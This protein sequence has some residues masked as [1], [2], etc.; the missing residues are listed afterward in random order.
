ML[1]AAGGIVTR[2]LFEPDGGGWLQDAGVLDRLALE[3]LQAAAEAMRGDGWKWIEVALDFPYG[4]TSGLRHIDGEVLELTTEERATYDALQAEYERLE[5][6]HA[7]AEDLP[8]EVDQRLSEIECAIS[9]LENRPVVYDPSAMARAGVFVSIASD[10]E[11][12]IER[13]YVRPEDELR[14]DVVET[15]AEDGSATRSIGTAPAA[16]VITVARAVKLDMAAAW[17]PTTANYLGRVPKTRILEA[18]REAK[19]EA[20]AQL[21][22]HLKKPDMAREAERLLDGTGWLPEP[23]RNADPAA[24]GEADDL[25]AF[26]EEPG[27][28]DPEEP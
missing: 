17:R 23:L 24:D 8:E 18:V 27:D 15:S 9:R 11:L 16:A 21:I 10:G 26:L 3:K 7:E 14:D 13:G 12:C 28:A 2:D 6:E 1:D 22:D 20:A 5:R 4:H 19:G 25:P